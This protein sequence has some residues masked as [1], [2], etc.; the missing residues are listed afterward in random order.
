MQNEKKKQVVSFV[1]LVDYCTKARRE[2]G[3]S[4]HITY[5]VWFYA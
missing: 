4:H 3:W 5:Y 2:P 1:V